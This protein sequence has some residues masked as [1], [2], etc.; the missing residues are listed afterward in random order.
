MTTGPV[1][2][3]HISDPHFG[4]EVAPVR[5]ALLRELHDAPPD[6]VVLSGDITQRAR[7]A[8]FRAARDFLAALP[9]VPRVCL[10]GNHDIPL[11]DV[12]TRLVRP[13]ARFRAHVSQELHP[14][15]V[16]ERCAVLCVDATSRV[17]HTD[18][19]LND[20]LIMQTRARLA[21]HVRP[22][23]VV[24]THQP[25]ASATESDRGNVAHGAKQA[26][27]S[28]IPAGADLF[29]GGHIH[30]P[31]CVP[32]RTL[33]RSRNGVLVQAGTCLSH[34]VRAG[35]PNSY[36]LIVLE[37]TTTGRRIR[38]DRRDFDS[39]RGAF[40]LRRRHEAHSADGAAGWELAEVVLA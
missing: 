1:R 32:V 4:T 34:R 24:V 23:R 33:D 17:R 39:A 37:K 16:D 5:D 27:E 11:F 22:F 20:A 25:L 36:N 6:L 10:P 8:Q 13:Y 9:A 21:Q 31:Y 19:V 15:F 3:A 28:W 7:R 30:L 40:D 35:I 12:F 38:V 26:L 18:G 2:I 29:L 14:Q